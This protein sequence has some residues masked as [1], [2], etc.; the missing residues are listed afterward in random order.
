MKI[1]NINKL[2]I[3][4]DKKLELMLAIQAVYQIKIEKQVFDYIETP[5]I[6]YLDELINFLNIDEFQSLIKDILEFE[7]ES[8]SISIALSLNDNYELDKT[9]AYLENNFLGNVDI[10]K[11]IKKFKQYAKKIKWDNFF[12]SH[13]S[14]YQQLALQFCDFPQDLDLNDIKNFYG[15]KFNSY[16]YIPSILVNGGFSYHDNNGNTFYVRGILWSK[17]EKKFVYDKK[18][19]LECLFHEFSHPIVNN[20][21][22]KYISSFSNL[23]IFFKDALNNKLPKTY[24]LKKY[25]YTNILYELTLLF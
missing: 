3:L 15:K 17:N 11:F 25:Y 7:D 4:V 1:K 18:Y 8:T 9:N 13:M 23:D 10:D 24:S 14:F 2:N 12:N 20:L 22:D 21:V 16:N 5:P 19:L 6:P